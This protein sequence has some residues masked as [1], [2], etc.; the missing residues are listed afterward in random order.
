MTEKLIAPLRLT[1]DEGTTALADLDRSSHRYTTVLNPFKLTGYPLHDVYFPQEESVILPSVAS[2][3]VWGLRQYRCA[4]RPDSRTGVRSNKFYYFTTK[5]TFPKNKNNLLNRCP[6]H[7]P[8]TR[9]WRQTTPTKMLL[10]CCCCWA[11][12]WGCLSF[13][14]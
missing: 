13:G 11:L 8:A 5:M 2:A 7:V 12:G 1:R 10:C 6:V 4:A 9:H 3:A 14:L